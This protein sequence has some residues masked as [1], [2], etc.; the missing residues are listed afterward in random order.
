MAKLYLYGIF[1]GNLSFSYIPK[2]LYGQIIDRCYWP[3]LEIIQKHNVP[4]GLELPAYT[5]QMIN[6]IDPEW[7][8]TLSDLWSKDYCQ[9]IGSGYIQ[10]IMPLIP[11]EANLKNLRYGN[12]VYQDLLGRTPNMA[13]VNEQVF[14]KGLPEIYKAAG[15]DS[16]VVNWD[17]A[18]PLQD[19]PELVYKPC[20]VKLNASEDDMPIIWHYTTAYRHL[21]NYIEQ[22]SDLLDYTS[23]LNSNIPQSGDR[24][25]AFYSSDWE[26]FDFKPWDSYPEGFP[27]PY[28]GEMNRL[29]ELIDLII[30]RDDIE[31]ISPNAAVQLFSDRPVIDPTSSSNPL[32]YKKQ[33]QHG[34]LRWAVGGRDS[35]RF[36][37][38]CYE[39]YN[40]LI[41][42][43][44]IIAQSPVQ[45]GLD[46]AQTSDLWRELCYLWSSDFRTFTTEEKYVEFRNRMGSAL[47]RI[48]GLTNRFSGNSESHDMAMISNATAIGSDTQIINFSLTSEKSGDVSIALDDGQIKPCQ[49]TNDS[50]MPGARTIIAKIPVSPN[51]FNT[52]KIL[53]QEYLDHKK[54]SQYFIHYETNTITTSAVELCVNPHK[55]GQIESITF[56]HIYHKPLITNNDTLLRHLGIDNEISKSDIYIQD[57][58]ESYKDSNYPGQMVYPEDSNAYPIFVPVLCK[59][60]T[61]LGVIWKTFRIYIDIP[62]VDIQIRFQWKDVLPKSFRIGNV[63]LEPSSFDNKTLQY[64][65]NNGGISD[66][67]FDL[68]GELVNHGASMTPNVTAHTSIGATEGW[69]VLRDSSRGVGFIT[70]QS[71]LYSVPMISHKNY[72][73]SENSFICSINHSLTEQDPTT[74]VLWRGHSTWQMSILGGREDILQDT[75]KSALS[76]NGSVHITQ[77]ANISN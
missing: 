76:F 8:R 18:L 71:M 34:M 43:E 20:R 11:Y 3:L 5:L 67:S 69:T 51:Q 38:Q 30:Q 24:T 63:S 42:A 73:N 29:S 77:N 4:F 31:F 64:I 52:A 10:S 57:V 40:K 1:H 25:L 37:S 66:E 46:A 35:V 23:W 75:K 21:Q 45:T 12:E 6:R 41:S 16:I 74:H 59:V 32:P 48:D 28:H 15:Y 22:K 27:S 2:D 53:Q 56:P 17:S 44:T 9:F 49:P 68:H 72:G 70:D 50:K 65:T 19:D 55:G 58:D 54:P 36:N 39:L 47:N 60:N 62:R 13:F 26:V 33:D 7:V 61:E 14:S